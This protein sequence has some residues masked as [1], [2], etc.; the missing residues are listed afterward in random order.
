MTQYILVLLIQAFLTWVMIGIIWYSQIV[1]YPLYNKIKDGFVEY[2]RAHIRRSAY[3]LGPI[4]FFEAITAVLL[5]ELA[6]AG[7]LTILA[8]VN[9][10]CLIFIWLSTFLFQL[11]Q[12]HRLAVRFSQKILDLLIS[13]NWIRTI[14]WTLKGIIMVLMVLYTFKS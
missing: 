2:E 5:I 12:H 7:H 13:S 8:T 1:H 3:L 11:H 4:M 9:L 10:I 6:P 14:F